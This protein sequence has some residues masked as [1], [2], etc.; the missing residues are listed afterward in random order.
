MESPKIFKVPIAR[1]GDVVLVLD[2]PEPSEITVKGEIISEASPIFKQMLASDPEAQRSRSSKNPQRLKIK[3]QHLLV[4]LVWL[5]SVL[6]GR[7][8]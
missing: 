5:C 7:I 3:D 2:T 1:D 4:G 8:L 6:H